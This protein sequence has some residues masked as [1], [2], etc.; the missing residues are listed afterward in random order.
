MSRLLG[1]MVVRNEADRYLAEAVAHTAGVVDLLVV[2]DDRSTDASVDVAVANG[3]L[4]V[5][6]PEDVP[7][8]DE[9]EGRFRSWAWS[10]LDLYATDTWVLVVD[11]DEQIATADGTTAP[12]A[13]RAVI[14]RCCDELDRAGVDAAVLTIRE[15]WGAD[16]NGTPLVRTD[17]EWGRISGARLARWTPDSTFRDAARGCGAIPTALNHKRWVPNP[18]IVHYGYATAA[19]RAAKHARYTAMR[20]RHNPNHI[21]SILSTPTLK[22]TEVQDAYP[23]ADPA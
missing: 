14:D 1:M 7:S 21:N 9:H 13:V 12:V 19:D 4:V 20:G 23:I 17:G 5:E 2:A 11:A 15:T 8:F 6:R 16:T 3:A 18:I 22:E 10:E